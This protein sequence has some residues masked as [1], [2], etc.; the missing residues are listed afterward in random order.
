[1]T[2]RLEK[3]AE[4]L[5]REQHKQDIKRLKRAK[6]YFDYGLAMLKDS[7]HDQD[8]TDTASTFFDALDKPMSEIEGLIREA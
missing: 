1:M 3:I 7:F 5:K 8:Y 4:S 6:E 2:T